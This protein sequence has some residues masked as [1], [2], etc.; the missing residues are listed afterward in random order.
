MK[1]MFFDLFYFPWEFHDVHV[2]SWDVM[3]FHESLV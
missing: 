2:A 3:E 1:K